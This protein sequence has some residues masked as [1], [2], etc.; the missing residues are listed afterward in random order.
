MRKKFDFPMLG[1]NRNYAATTQPQFTCPDMKNVRPY[2]VLENRARG[3]QRPGLSRLWEQILGAYAFLP[4][5]YSDTSAFWRLDEPNPK[6]KAG[7]IKDSGALGLDG[8]ASVD[9]TSVVGPLGRAGVFDGSTTYITLPNADRYGITTD[10]TVCAWMLFSSVEQGIRRDLF[11]WGTDSNGFSLST[12]SGKLTAFINNT[13]LT[14]TTVLPVNKWNFVCASVKNGGQIWLFH[15]GI[16]RASLS[17]G[18]TISAG[19]VPAYIGRYGGDVLHVYSGNLCH[20][21]LF[22]RQLLEA[23]IASLYENI[24][25]PVVACGQVSSVGV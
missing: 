8:T 14:Y 6:S 3:G 23:E 4:Q 25:S 15:N 10:F 20:V 7:V 19:S 18:G 12:V 5:T 22:K 13:S 1:V 2:D 21:M 24:G 11:S 17:F 9:M 16:R